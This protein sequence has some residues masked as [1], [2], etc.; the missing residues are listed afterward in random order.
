MESP[1]KSNNGEN[2]SKPIALLMT[3]KVSNK[4]EI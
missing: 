4:R 3:F 2:G 1:V